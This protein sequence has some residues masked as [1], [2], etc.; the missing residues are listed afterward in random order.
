MRNTILGA[1]LAVGMLGVVTSAGCGAVPA[2]VVKSIADV[3][4]SSRANN[5]NFRRVLDGY[6]PTNEEK[7][8]WTASTIA[9]DDLTP[10]V[11]KW[12]QDHAKE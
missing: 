6:V 1:L 8:H 5:A 2:T 11:V 7:K 4:S 9:M 3:D 12:A 10:K